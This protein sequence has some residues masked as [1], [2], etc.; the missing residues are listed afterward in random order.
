MS[1]SYKIVP[2]EDAPDEECRK[3]LGWLEDYPAKCFPVTQPDGPRLKFLHYVAC[4]LSDL[5]EFYDRAVKQFPPG[6]TITP[7]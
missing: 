7:Q 2:T 5:A 4:P 1:T 6:W 3:F